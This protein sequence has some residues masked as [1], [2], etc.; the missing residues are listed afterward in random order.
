MANH[1]ESDRRAGGRPNGHPAMHNFLGE[2]IYAGDERIGMVGLASRDGGY[3]FDSIEDLAGLNLICAQFL[4]GVEDARTRAALQAAQTNERERL[5]AV[6]ATLEDGV[7]ILDTDGAVVAENDSFPRLL[8]CSLSESLSDSAGGPTSLNELTALHDSVQDARLRHALPAPTDVALL[9][10]GE[11]RWLRLS[12]RGTT[13]APRSSQMV[14]V[15]RDVTSDVR[16][17]ELLRSEAQRLGEV[18]RSRAAALAASRS[19]LDR[20]ARELKASEE[21]FSNLLSATPSAV[22]SLRSVAAWRRSATAIT[23]CRS[24]CHASW[25]STTAPP[26]SRARRRRLKPHPTIAAVA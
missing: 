17:S 5:A 9:V 16:H 15:V 25:P 22:S 1:V 19:A 11:P 21:V 13:G 6:F 14:L 20:T 24:G 23:T 12:M 7:A 26:R 8:G 2:P 18:A 4:I 10:R 3:D